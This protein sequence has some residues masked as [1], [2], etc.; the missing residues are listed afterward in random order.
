MLVTTGVGFNPPANAA[1]NLNSEKTNAAYK[2]LYSQ[3]LVP[4]RRQ[5]QADIDL[6]M[7][8]KTSLIK[9][10]WDYY[11]LKDFGLYP[12]MG[13]WKSRLV[14]VAHGFGELLSGSAKCPSIKP[15]CYWEKRC[16]TLI[17]Q[18]HI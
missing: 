4:W 7:S 10:I 1:V 16:L 14:E 18:S 2:A 8:G 15:A 17:F 9:G 11:T 6:Q 12:T 13:F 3:T 5:L